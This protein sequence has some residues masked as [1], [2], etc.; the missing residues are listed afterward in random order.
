MSIFQQTFTNAQIVASTGVTNDQL[1]NWIRRDLIV[2]QGQI[3]GGGSPGR[4]RRFS[5]FNLME[6]AIA[7]ALLDAGLGDLQRT[8]QAAKHFAHVGRGE[9]GDRPERLPGFPFKDG[10]TLLIVGP[11]DAREYQVTQ[12]ERPLALYAAIKQHGIGALVI[13]ASAVFETTLQRAGQD[14][15][16]AMREAY[17]N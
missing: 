4:H 12:Q 13:D 6:I 14:P 9:I 16:L 15:A 1:Q 17:G 10:K 3:E 2:G 5:F 7:K 8:T 11:R